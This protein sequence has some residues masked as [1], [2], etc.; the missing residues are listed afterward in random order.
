MRSFVGVGQGLGY[1]WS[2]RGGCKMWCISLCV[3]VC[4]Y[5]VHMFAG[6]WW[7]P[8]GVRA[9][10]GLEALSYWFAPG[11]P[12]FTPLTVQPSSTHPIPLLQH[13]PQLSVEQLRS[14][15]SCWSVRV[16]SLLNK[17]QL[18]FRWWKLTAECWTLGH[19]HW[20]RGCKSVVT[21]S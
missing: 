5:W 14:W 17:H 8:H 16:V 3:S 15:D 19:C 18:F 11:S 4:V 2:E 21:N 7:I 10:L 9:N 6:L 12:S 1:E 20:M 13:F